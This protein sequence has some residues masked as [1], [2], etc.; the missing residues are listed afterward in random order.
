MHLLNRIIL[1]ACLLTAQGCL[2]ETAPNI[3]KGP[4]SG[5]VAAQRMSK[6]RSDN[7][8]SIESHTFT[9]V[10]NSRLRGKLAM[11]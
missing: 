8:P 11:P 9:T 6:V 7:G 3:V 10:M 1:V 5:N 4:I 2:P